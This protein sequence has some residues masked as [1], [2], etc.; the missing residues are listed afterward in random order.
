MLWQKHFLVSRPFL[1][2]AILEAAPDP[3]AVACISLSALRTMHSVLASS[4]LHHLYQTAS[5]ALAVMRRRG[6]AST[7]EYWSGNPITGVVLLP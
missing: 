3:L 1:E 2:T 5:R 6:D 7:V 4:D